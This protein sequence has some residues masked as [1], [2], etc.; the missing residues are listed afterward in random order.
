MNRIKSLRDRKEYGRQLCDRVN[1][2]LQGEIN[3]SRMA[4]TVLYEVLQSK[5]G[6]MQLRGW[7][8][9]KYSLDKFTRWLDKEHG[10]LPIQEINGKIAQGFVS[11]LFACGYG[12]YAINNIRGAISALMA[13]YIQ[14]NEGLVN[15]FSRTRKAKV[16]IGKNIAFTDSQKAEIT[17]LLTPEMR[18]FTR[19]IYFTYIRPIEILRLRCQDIRLDLGVIIIQGRYSKNRKQAS[20]TIPDEFFDELSAMKYDKFPGEWFIF[21]KGLKP[22]AGALGRNSVTR[23]HSQV[24]R[25][26]GYNAD[27]TLYSWKHTGVVAAYRSGIEIYA[28]MRQLRHGSLDMT[29]VYLKS[30]GLQENTE[31]RTKMV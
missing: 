14:D 13:F 11:Y 20:I 10:Q 1:Q 22:G 3:F 31:F 7:Q 29:Q 2:L 17:E 6:T 8:S 15:P 23:Y 27:Y 5:R 16:A 12:G 9:Y 28:I 25:A 26:L 18:L 21:G 24:L 30:L 4:K 19:M